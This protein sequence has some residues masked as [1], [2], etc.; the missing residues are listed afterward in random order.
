MA[1]PLLVEF[2]RPKFDRMNR[3]I[4]SVPHGTEQGMNKVRCD[5]SDSA[6]GICKRM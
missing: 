1:S 2:I 6:L 3:S 4:A 5:I